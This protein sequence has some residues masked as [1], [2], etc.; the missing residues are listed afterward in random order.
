MKCRS[1]A[2]AP[3]CSQRSSSHAHRSR[4]QSSPPTNHSRSAIV[5]VSPIGDAGWTFQHD[6]GRKEMEKALGGKVVTKYVESVPEGRR[7]RTRDPRTGA[8][9]QQ[10]HFHDVLRLH[11][12]DA[13][14][15]QGVSQDRLRARDRLQD[16]HQRRHLQRALLR[17]TLPRRAG[18]GQDDQEQH[19]RLRR[20]VPDTRSRDGH[21]RLHARHEERQSRRPK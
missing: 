12:S 3:R 2:I 1:S 14:G 15:R 5:Y 21:Q 10:A 17:G 11:E 16:R 7:R 4:R 9:R 13:Q 8:V 6:Q 20:G 19:R 18:R